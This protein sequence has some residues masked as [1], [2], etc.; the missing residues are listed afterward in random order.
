MY[1]SGLRSKLLLTASLVLLSSGTA[2][3]DSGDYAASSDS[4]GS[5]FAWGGASS[6]LEAGGGAALVAGL[7]DLFHGSSSGVHANVVAVSGPADAPEIST[8]GSAAGLALLVGG[9][10]IA[11][12]RRRAYQS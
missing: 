3:A 2:F 10:F 7:V 12:G 4:T 9:V 11:R 6:L 1:T 8:S 5:G